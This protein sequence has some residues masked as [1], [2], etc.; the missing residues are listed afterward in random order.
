VELAGRGIAADVNG[1]AADIRQRDERDRTRTASPLRQAMDA[2]L[3]DTT[4]LKLD[5][6]EEKVLRLVRSRTANGKEVGH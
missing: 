5:E 3:I 4:G 2:D 6:V 1:V